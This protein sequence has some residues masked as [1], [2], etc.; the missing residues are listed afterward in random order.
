MKT[1]PEYLACSIG[2]FFGIPV[3]IY[4]NGGLCCSYFPVRLPRDPME[5]CRKEI[6]AVTEHVSYYV[7]PQFHYYG[8]LNSGNLKI[9]IGP[10]AQITPDEQK[11]RELSFQADV[12]QDE[13]AAFIEGMAAIGR[14]PVEMLLQ[15]LCT[16]NHLLNSGEKLEFSDI[17][18]HETEQTLLKMNA[19]ERRTARVY[20]ED[21][22]DRQMHNTLEIEETLMDLVRRGETSTLRSWLSS[23]PAVHGGTIARDQLR[24][25]KNLFI[26]TA[27]LTSR[28]AIRGGMPEDE[29]FTLSDAY[30]QRAE[31]LS[32]YSK[33]INLQYSMLLE[34]TE[35][36][37]K[38]HRG[39]FTK[40]FSLDVTNFVRR[41]LSEP[42]SVERM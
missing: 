4:E 27:T 17:A 12:P 37:E 25:V 28:A 36:V 22:P 14:M 8:I 31:L 34:F 39:K 30:I 20:E 7:T 3:R 18:I 38:L 16:L 19:E 42:V 6:L 29:A 41:H 11:L 5:I 21:S 9:V 10:T 24:Q 26:V 1:D 13:T 15:F 35:Q 32:S 2:R 23:A 33:I 40:K